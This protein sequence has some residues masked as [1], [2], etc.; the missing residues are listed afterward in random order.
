MHKIKSYSYLLMAAF[1]L[2]AC[3]TL[4]AQTAVD[5]LQKRFEQYRID[6]PQEKVYAHLSQNVYLTGE[7]VWFKIY[8]VDGVQHRPLNTSKV[9][10]V[11]I[12]D[13]ENRAVAH[14]KIS[15]KDGEGHGSIF[16]PTS[17]NSGNYT[18]RAYTQWMRNFSP[19]FFFHK[20]ITIVNS[21]RKLELEKTNVTERFQAQFFPEGGNLVY[22]LKSKV[23]FQVT[24]PDGKGINF[25]GVLLN[26]ANDTIA[27]IKPLKFGIGNFT[28]TPVKGDS[29][30]VILTDSLG[31][32]KT[33]QLPVPKPQ[34]VVMEV[35]DSTDML[36]VHVSSNDLTGDASEFF[37]FVVHARQIVSS[38]G[39]RALR[40]KKTTIL[41]PKKDLSEGISHIT[42]FDGDLHPICERLYFKRSE[43]KL[44]LTT[45][46]NQSEYGIRRKV[47]VD[48]SAEQSGE[49]A[50]L[51]V[52]VV[53]A[54]SL[55]GN[56]GG[57]LFN[58]LW[59][60][61][62]LKGEIE[63]PNYY[64]ETN[65]PETDMALDNLM[66]THGWRRF[67]WD[68]VLAKEKKRPIFIPEYRGHLI[69]G[70]VTDGNGKPAPGVSTY[71][72]SPGKNIQLYT[73][74]S[75]SNGEIQYE[76]KD[77][78]GLKKIVVQTNSEQDSTSKIEIHNPYSNTFAVRRLSNLTMQPTVA[79]PLLERS[80]AMQIQDIY[81]GD[82]A[83]PQIAAIDS[84]SF[85]GKS[86][87]TYFLDDYTRFTVMEE[88]MR[89]YVPGVMVRKRKDG[90]HFLV[91]DNVR[92]SLFQEDPLVLLDGMPIFDIDKI[93]A[94]DP[95]R[96]KK[97][98]VVTNRYFLGPLIFPGIVSYMTYTGDLAGFQLDPKNV[99]LDY[100][101]LQRQRIFYSPLYENQKQRDSRMP[102]RR[103]LLF[104]TPH[105]RLDK[106]GKQQIEF[107]TSDLTG[108][109]TIVVEGMTSNGYAGS[110]T[111]SFVVKQFNN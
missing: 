50:S 96:I 109:Y 99:S 13:R 31:S 97:L 65:G 32:S 100:E 10:Y 48:L 35:R 54:D 59:L 45:H 57:E 1:L 22:E 104:W 12:L 29:Y 111:S 102:D 78:Y 26:S 21:F 107:Y 41:I 58:Y 46:T 98:D 105:V 20:S 40:S 94:F 28:F 70:T 68:E 38:I 67:S 69:R 95:L 16:L 108:N 4:R 44:A 74:R 14:S 103:N 34:G 3:T 60:T 2:F 55:Q 79:K 27:S 106:E 73:A 77:F 43:K 37:Y 87:E 47:T 71:L 76:T 56:L 81:Y 52:A 75:R 72:S 61:S 11:E 101:G 7:T 8:Y 19:E 5:T 6:F 110:A 33:I 93:M 25:S 66:L 64:F 82:A 88:V 18:V 24:T 91:L 62:D 63:S 17:I 80:V 92:K 36:A 89:E 84:A 39:V 42:I 23:A 86:S 30:R 85:Y 53:K 90:F 83:K 15:L 49:G 51:S 9:A